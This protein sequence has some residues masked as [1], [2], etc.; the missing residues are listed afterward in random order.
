MKSIKSSS[1]SAASF[2]NFLDFL[3]KFTFASNFALV[4]NIDIAFL[5]IRRY[6]TCKRIDDISHTM[7]NCLDLS[8]FKDNRMIFLGVASTQNLLVDFN[9]A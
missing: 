8:I 1:N 6:N 4:S 9:R 5:D 3:N 7:E 2:A